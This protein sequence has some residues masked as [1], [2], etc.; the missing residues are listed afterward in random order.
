MTTQLKTEKGNSF[1]ILYGINMLTF[2]G[3]G[4][5][6]LNLQCNLVNLFVL[7]AVLLLL[8]KSYI[9]YIKASS[10]FCS[11]P[12]SLKPFEKFEQKL[13]GRTLACS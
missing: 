1:S 13:I 6:A 7:F 2:A 9:T 8:Y 10:D 4:Q 11:F 3:P 5:M 12:L